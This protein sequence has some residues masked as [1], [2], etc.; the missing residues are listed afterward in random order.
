MM[1]FL[2]YTNEPYVNDVTFMNDSVNI[3]LTCTL[4]ILNVFLNAFTSW[5]LKKK[6]KFKKREQLTNK[7]KKKTMHHDK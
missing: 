3:S 7:R 6:K 1:K 4:R 5:I 2:L